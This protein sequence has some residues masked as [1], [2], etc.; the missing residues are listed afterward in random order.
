MSN[1][2][3]SLILFCWGDLRKFQKE[4][5][6]TTNSY[7]DMKTSKAYNLHFKEHLVLSWG[8]DQPWFRRLSDNMISVS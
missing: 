8:C 6:E 3:N 7:M 1:C 4:L 2:A 5:T